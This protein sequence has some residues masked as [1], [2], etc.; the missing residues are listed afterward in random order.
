MVAVRGG[1]LR[2][3]NNPVAPGG[4]FGEL[5]LEGRL[6]DGYGA[7]R[8]GHPVTHG[9]HFFRA[10]LG[11]NHGLITNPVDHAAV[12]LFRLVRDQGHLFLPGSQVRDGHTQ[13]LGHHQ[14]GDVDDIPLGNPLAAAVVQVAFIG[15]DACNTEFPECFLACRIH[16]GAGMPCD[17]PS[18]CHALASNLEL[19]P[20]RQHHPANGELVNG[21]CAGL[22]GADESAGSQCLHG[23]KL[24]NDDIALCHSGHANGQGNGECG[25][26]A[27]GNHRNRQADGH[28]NHLLDGVT[29]IQDHQACQGGNSRQNAEGDL[30][31]E[32]ADPDH[33]RRLGRGF[34]GNA[35]GNLAK[36]GRRGGSDHPAAPAPMGDDAAG[37]ALV[38]AL[39]QRGTVIACGIDI[40]GNR[41]GFPRQHGLIHCQAAGAEQL[42]ISGHLVPGGQQDDIARDDLLDVNGDN[43]AVPKHVGCPFHHLLQR[44]SRLLSRKLLHG[45]DDRVYQQN[46]QN[47][48]PA[49]GLAEGK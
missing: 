18:R 8:G 39:S 49:R 12:G 20:V 13:L 4:Q 21:Q 7:V 19:P 45:A 11:V 15:E 30:I 41:Q 17:F 6:V 31:G 22:V 29:A 47:K 48:N 25:R 10:A 34:A 32:L 14:K 38:S 9:Q 24:A 40:L 1:S 42:K 5:A 35:L 44:S 27:L 36:L 23:D 46:N 28:E 26:Q 2:K 16:L 37:K 3:G 33:Q 43:L